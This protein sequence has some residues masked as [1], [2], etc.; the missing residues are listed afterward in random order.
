MKTFLILALSQ[1]QKIP[2]LTQSKLE[3]MLATSTFRIAVY[4]RAEMGVVGGKCSH[5]ANLT[6]YFQKIGQA[7]LIIGQTYRNYW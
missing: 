2:A 7:L 5:Y 1:Y 6:N 4:A 3:D